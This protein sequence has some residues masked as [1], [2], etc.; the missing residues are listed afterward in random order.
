MAR[1][2][3]QRHGGGGG[4]R[5]QAEFVFRLS[6]PVQEDRPDFKKRQIIVQLT[7]FYF[8]ISE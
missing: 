5:K 6:C 2:G 4:G 3:P 1:V 7:N 8:I